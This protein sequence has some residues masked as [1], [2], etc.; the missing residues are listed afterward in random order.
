MNATASYGAFHLEAAYFVQ[1]APNRQIDL[2]KK[3]YYYSLKKSKNQCKLSYSYRLRVA[4]GIKD[5]R[6]AAAHATAA[7]L[8]AMK[9]QVKNP[10]LN[11]VEI[12]ENNAEGS[13][14]EGGVML[15][16]SDCEYEGGVNCYWSDS[17]GGDYFKLDPEDFDGGDYSDAED[18]LLVSRMNVKPG[19]KQSRMHDGWFVHDGHKISQSMVFPFDH[20]VFPNEPKGIK[21]ILT[22][23]G[24]FQPGLRG[25]CQSK[26][27]G[28]NCCNKH[29]LERQPDF[30][31]QKSL[32]QEVIEAAGHLCIFFCLNFI[33]SRILLNSFG[34]L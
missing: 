29:I 20:P 19:G 18:A 32:V 16:D 5:K 14:C 8:L 25:K 17:D 12:L 11:D 30:C 21:A 33:A 6:K 3:K 4:M 1:R 34:V 31:E 2:R 9:A 27:D 13:A 26:C 15:E 23:R 24:L 7:R 22:E 10:A 28:E